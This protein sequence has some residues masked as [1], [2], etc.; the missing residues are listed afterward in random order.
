MSFLYKFYFLTEKAVFQIPHT[1]DTESVDKCG[2]E[3]GGRGGWGGWGAGDGGG[4]G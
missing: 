2:N 3:D 4:S 1:A